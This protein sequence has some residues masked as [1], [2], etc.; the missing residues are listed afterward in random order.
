MNTTETDAR[1]YE[2]HIVHYLLNAG[3]RRVGADG[4]RRWHAAEVLSA[5]QAYVEQRRLD[6]RA[7][8]E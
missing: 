5:D 1:P 8:H 7:A 3:W 6:E 2:A 4:F